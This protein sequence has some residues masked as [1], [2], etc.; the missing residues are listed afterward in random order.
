MKQEDC[1]DSHLCVELTMCLYIVVNL[2]HLPSS[3]TSNK[4]ERQILP[5]LPLKDKEIESEQP[6]NIKTDYQSFHDE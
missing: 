1:N 3:I 4:P 5:L 6:N 2:A